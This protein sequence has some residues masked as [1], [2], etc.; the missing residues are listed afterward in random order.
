[1]LRPDDR[2]LLFESLRPPLGYDFDQAIG[3]TY[4]LDLLALLTVPLAFT[5]FAV[6]SED[7]RVSAHPLAML[8]AVRGHA[9]RITLFCQAAQINVPPHDQLLYAHLEPSVVEVAAS[10]R[11]GVFHPKVWL[12]RF[13]ADGEPTRYRLLCLS[14]NLTFD[15]SWD[16]LLALD[17]TVA[18]RQ[19][20]ISANHPIGDFIEALPE[21]AL[22]DLSPRVADRVALF[23]SELRRV[24]WEHPEGVEELQFWPLGIPGYSDWP[25]DGRIDRLL[26]VSPFLG[27]A[28][29]ERLA[30]GREAI[31]VSRPE[32]LEQVG[33]TGVAGYERTLVLTDTAEPEPDDERVATEQADGELVGLHAKVYVAE[34]GREASVWVGSANATTA[35]FDLNVE[36]LVELVGGKR[37]LGIDQLLEPVAGEMRFADLLEEYRP[38]AQAAPETIA[39]ALERDADGIKQALAASL[40]RAAVV[41]GDRDSGYAVALFGEL[42]PVDL[43]QVPKLLAWP[44]TL[45]R[46]SAERVEPDAAPLVRFEAIALESLT[47]FWA[48][49]L[50]LERDGFTHESRFVLQLPLENEPDG[51]RK[52]ILRRLLSD[53]AGVLRYLLFLLQSA[54]D[55]IAAAI[56]AGSLGQADADDGTGR[57]F[58]TDA[59]LELLLKTLDR[60]PEQLDRVAQVIRDLQEEG[61]EE[62]LPEGFDE[63]WMP[64]W[65]ARERMRSHATDG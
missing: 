54:Q 30:D 24:K 53:R 26:V 20:A 4:S 48:F 9:D 6:D 55:P 42:D 27:S 50:V 7:G 25:F 17:G 46:G 34:A 40:M 60:D 22:R 63:I 21:L 35:G 23:E 11:G 44:I 10:R 51:R 32:S 65:Q 37:V 19:R 62:L 2:K 1:M 57:L 59:V 28:R 18:N 29:L 56:A 33:E 14:R 8:D 58:G 41:G 38:P 39:T 5:L 61:E 15:R 16:T 52:A 64:V 47:C 12:L 49:E 13:V 31:L 3:T 43:S 45:A 36:F